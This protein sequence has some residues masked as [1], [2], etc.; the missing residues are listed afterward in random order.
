[1]QLRSTLDQEVDVGISRV[2]RSLIKERSPW[3]GWIVA[4]LFA[5]GAVVAV[6]RGVET[7][8][9]CSPITMRYE[10]ANGG[11]IALHMCGALPLT[12]TPVAL[13]YQLDLRLTLV[14]R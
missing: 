14:A 12:H 3:R 1:M 11:A 7:N 8:P 6:T 9:D 5:L 13:R 2:V 4:A 10:P